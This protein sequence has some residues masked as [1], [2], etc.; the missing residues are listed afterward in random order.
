MY[1]TSF[2]AW[3]WKRG[4]LAPVAVGEGQVNLVY[5]GRVVAMGKV[6]KAL[7]LIHFDDESNRSPVAFPV[8]IRLRNSHVVNSRAT[9]GVCS[10]VNFSGKPAVAGL[11]AHGG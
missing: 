3:K 4:P 9:G 8:A 5:D 7:W 11:R 2:P 6:S 1:G 10:A